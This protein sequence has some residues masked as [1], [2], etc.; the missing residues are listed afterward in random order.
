KYVGQEIEIETLLGLV[1]LKV[2]ADEA[3]DAT[4]GTGVVKVTPAHDATDFEIWQRHKDEIPGP[5]QV[6]D[7]YGKL[8]EH[9]GPYQGLKIKEAREKIVAD[10]ETRGLI[11]KVDKDYKH[12]VQLCYKCGTV[13]E[14]LIVPQWYVAM[15]KELPDGRASLRDMAVKAVSEKSVTI[16]PERFIKVFTHWMENLHDWPISRQIWWGIRIPVWYCLACGEI[17][18]NAKIKSRWFIVRHGITDWNKEDRA[19]GRSDIPLNEEGR[20]QARAI[21]QKLKQQNIELIIS[22]PLLRAKETADII[23]ETIGVEVI[24]DAALQEKSHGDADGMT[25]DEIRNKYGDQYDYDLKVPNGESYRELEARIWQAFRE[26]KEKH[27]HKNIVITG[28]GGA[29][30]TL[31]G[32]IRNLTPE[33]ML[34]RPTIKNGEVVLLDILEA[35]EKCGNDLYEQD[36]DTLDTWFSSGQWPYATLMANEKKDIDNYFPTNTLVTG[37]DILFFWVA[38][39]I[40]FSYYRMGKEPFKTV[41]LHG[42]VRDKDKQKMSKSKGNVVDPLGIIDTYGADALRFALIFATAAESDIALSE[43]RIRGMKHFANKLWNIARFVLANCETEK[44]IAK[45]KLKATTDADKEILGHLQKTIDEVTKSLEAFRLHEAAQE[46]YQFIWHELADIYLEAS[47]VQLQD[48]K[49][50]KNTEGLLFY[51]L[52]TA[53]KLLHPFMPFVTEEIFQKMDGSGKLLMVEKWPA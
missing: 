49:L 42:L 44:V 51:T 45:T 40:M 35:C 24:V 41:L 18:I 27:G 3:V 1:K 28:H 4:F 8:N 22:S 52:H 26:H 15:T 12:N 19:Q 23:A 7:K 5:K 39:M 46:I 33:A 30:R 9:T 25:Q 17:K 32:K 36:S 20:A 37:S 43:D 2:I 50:K 14:P 47:K 48:E 11:T 38:R 13:I 53:L 10:M 6:I 21:A 34:S 31:I 29:I 16:V